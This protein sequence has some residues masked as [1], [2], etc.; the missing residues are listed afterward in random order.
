M[1]ASKLKLE[2]GDFR[3]PFSKAMTKWKMSGQGANP[4]PEK[5]DEDPNALYGADFEDFTGG[6]LIQEYCFDL[7]I[8]N[9][10]LLTSHTIMC[11]AQEGSLQLHRR[12]L[13]HN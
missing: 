11:D 6:D 8:H 10:D 2:F 9:A 1:V 5:K 13:K 4:A 12:T 7:N 3:G